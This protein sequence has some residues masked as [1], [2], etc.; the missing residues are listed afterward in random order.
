M[1]TAELPRPAF[2]TA[3]DATAS[4]V[5][6]DARTPEGLAA[7]QAGW[8]FTE[9]ELAEIRRSSVVSETDRA[10]PLFGGIFAGRRVIPDAEALAMDTNIARLKVAEGVALNRY[11]RGL[12]GAR[13]QEAA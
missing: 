4:V 10:H 11:E 7:M 6:I 3:S 1:R 9:L 2:Q 13:V 8:C 5:T 12:I